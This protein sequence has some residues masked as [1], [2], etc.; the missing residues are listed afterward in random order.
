[1]GLESLSRADNIVKIAY[2]CALSSRSTM[3]MP[4]PLLSQQ[5]M[6][7]CVLGNPRRGEKI[8]RPTEGLLIPQH[9]FWPGR[10]SHEARVSVLWPRHGMAFNGLHGPPTL[11]RRP[12]L[13][14]P[15]VD[16]GILHLLALLQPLGCVGRLPH[17]KLASSFLA[18]FSASTV[19]FLL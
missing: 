3:E 11:L 2:A 1:M 7:T 5:V 12:Y 18:A 13:N 6:K 14:P 17:G 15:A 4:R 19:M 16:R 8:L 10:T 9:V